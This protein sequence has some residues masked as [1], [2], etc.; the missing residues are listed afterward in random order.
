MC[1]SVSNPLLNIKGKTNDD[2]NTRQNLAEIG[3]LDQLHL[4]SD[5]NKIYLPP[6][7]HTLSR[8]EN[9][10]FCQCLQVVNMP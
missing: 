5:G 1:D 7:C 8:N 4:M 9:T 10:S 6:T 3:I 2:L